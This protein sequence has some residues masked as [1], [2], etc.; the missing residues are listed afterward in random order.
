MSLLRPICRCCPGSDETVSDAGSVFLQTLSAFLGSAAASLA[1]ANASVAQEHKW[2]VLIIT[3]DQHRADCLGCYGNPVVKTPAVDR[4]AADGGRFENYFVDA[5]PC[6]PSRV[7]M[8]TGGY[9]DTPPV[10]TNAY[11]LPETE[12]TTAKILNAQ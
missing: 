10:P 7:R 1:A 5:P 4:L 3:N 11:V 9:P 12:Q 2:N 6:V 8:H